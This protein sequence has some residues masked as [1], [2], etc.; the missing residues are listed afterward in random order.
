MTPAIFA[1]FV[2]WIVQSTLASCFRYFSGGSAVL[3]KHLWDALGARDTPPPMPVLGARAGRAFQ[4]L[5]EALPV[6]L[7]LALLLELHDAPAGMGRTGAWVFVGA[8]VLYV[9]AYLSAIPGL[10]SSV[11][12]AGHAGLAMMAV[13]V[14]AAVS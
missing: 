8:R 5:S 10:R 7:G 12:L 1:V 9:P 11:W 13:A 4:N 3:G 14:W 2:L 6:F